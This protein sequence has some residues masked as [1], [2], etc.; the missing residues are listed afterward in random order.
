MSDNTKILYDDKINKDYS[1][2]FQN[3]DLQDMLEQY[4]PLTSVSELMDKDFNPGRFRNYTFLKCVYGNNQSQIT[5]NLSPLKF[6][7]SFTFNKNNNA[8]YE[9]DNA[10][11][12]IKNTNNPQVTAFIYPVN[13]TFNYRVISGTNMLSPHSFGIAIDLKSSSNDYHKWTSREK[14]TIRLRQYPEELVKIFEK[15]N[16]I[17]GG[18]WGYFDILH[19]EYRPEI[20]IKARYFTNYDC[21]KEWYQDFP[22][23]DYSLKCINLIDNT[24]N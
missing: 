5:K 18:K 3:S 7:P 19:F 13:G 12:E 14:G 17:W 9:L 24:I 11:K 20:I 8:A 10:L 16:F 21:N 15:H 23:D 22:T 2:K 4:Y 6:S 1:L